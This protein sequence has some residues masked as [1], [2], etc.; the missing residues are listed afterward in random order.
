MAK[1][2]YTSSQTI[3][4]YKAKVRQQ[5]L[6]KVVVDSAE[7]RTR[8]ELLDMVEELFETTGGGSITAE[9]LRAFCHILLKS[10]QNIS[11][12]DVVADSLNSTT[13]A[14]NLP[15]TDPGVDGQVYVHRGALVVSRG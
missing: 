6:N 7:K 12:D 4:G 10:I 5:T 13:M 14:N 3:N 11:D 2:D 8:A 1:G 9:T 15:S